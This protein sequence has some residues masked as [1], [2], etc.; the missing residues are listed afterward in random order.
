MDQIIVNNRP[1]AILTR[2]HEGGGNTG[3]HKG[4]ELLDGT[5]RLDLTRQVRT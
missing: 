5:T 3:G 4:L 2:V 1:A